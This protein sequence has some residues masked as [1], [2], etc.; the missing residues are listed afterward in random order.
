MKKKSNLINYI[1]IAV[2]LIVC[3]VYMLVTEGVDSIAYAFSQLNYVWIAVGLFLMITYWFSE[4]M[5]LYVYAKPVSPQ[6]SFGAVFRV[7]MIGQLFNCIT[8]FA[9]GGQPMQAYYLSKSKMT[10]AQAL[11]ALLSRFIVYQGT[12][13][14]ISALIILFR[15]DYF[16]K[17]VAGFLSLAL[18]GFAINTIVIVCL[19]LV[20]FCKSFVLTVLRWGVRL[21]SKIRWRKGRLV[22]DPEATYQK[23][24][25][26]VEA[27][28][29]N[30][31][32]VRKNIGMSLRSM[33]WSVL[34]LLAYFML[35]FFI[36]LAFGDTANLD[37][38]NMICAQA[39]VLMISS[40][41]PSPGAAG[42]AEVSF[43][44]FFKKFLLAGTVPYA[45]LIWRVFVF[46]LPIL[47]GALFLR[48]TQAKDGVLPEN[49]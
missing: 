10:V 20:G 5:A 11:T 1:I 48:G 24:A 46:Y 19:L 6:V 26:S 35:P 17:N 9:S 18:V 14:V 45:M 2:V 32:F 41:V 49:L 42:A 8:P 29:E 40:F 44:F 23:A 36:G 22:S 39:F 38:F 25:E 34:Q 15:Y 13:T 43:V 4:S 16:S 3:V 31:K 7:T 28:A 12:L 47:V 33:F 21:G 30:M 27:F 37:F